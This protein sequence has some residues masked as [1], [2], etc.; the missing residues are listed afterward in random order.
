MA[1][2]AKTLGFETYEGIISGYPLFQVHEINPLKRDRIVY[3]EKFEVGLLSLS[4]DPGLEVSS[5]NLAASGYP[6]S[7]FC[8]TRVLPSSQVLGRMLRWQNVKI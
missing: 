6:R 3:W 2:K 1:A 4:A 5:A 8:E 7:F